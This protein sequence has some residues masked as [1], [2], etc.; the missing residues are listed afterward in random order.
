M[1]EKSQLRPVALRLGKLEETPEANMVSRKTVSLTHIALLSA[2]ACLCA[3]VIYGF[4]SGPTCW[5]CWSPRNVHNIE[6]PVLSAMRDFAGTHSAVSFVPVWS[7][8]HC[9]R[10]WEP[11]TPWKIA[12]PSKPRLIG[13]RSGPSASDFQR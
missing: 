12:I 8:E 11:L 6:I 3:G 13:S 7:C 9:N 2:V 4:L 5:Q 1:K 10:D